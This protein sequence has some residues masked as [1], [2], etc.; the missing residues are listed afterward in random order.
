[1]VTW[2]LGLRT[3][4]AAAFDFENW[5]CN[6]DFSYFCYK[7]FKNITSETTV[8]LPRFLTILTQRAV[9]KFTFICY[10]PSVSSLQTV[11]SVVLLILK[12]SSLNMNSL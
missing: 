11:E 7:F 5:V 1:M 6:C 3:C 8:Y 4:C 9:L 12:F 10:S 2:W